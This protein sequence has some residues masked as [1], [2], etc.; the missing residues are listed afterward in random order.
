MSTLSPEFIRGGN[1]VVLHELAQRELPTEGRF[2]RD[3]RKMFGA[4]LLAKFTG[5]V[6]LLTNTMI[7]CD[8]YEA[9]AQ[10]LARGMQF[11]PV[12]SYAVAHAFVH[13]AV[14]SVIPGVRHARY[15]FQPE[16]FLMIQPRAD[17]S[18]AV[19]SQGGYI[20]AYDTEVVRWVDGLYTLGK[21]LSHRFTA[22]QLI[23]PQVQALLESGRVSIPL[24]RPTLSGIQLEVVKPPAANYSFTIYG[25]KYESPHWITS[26]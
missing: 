24:L 18:N 11:L 6:S 22:S 2:Q 8:H 9:I 20:D 13:G 26:R 23:V 25:K 21:S 19:K 10:E 3:A 4:F 1:L 12:E 15:G 14:K 5:N 16:R 7:W 17:I